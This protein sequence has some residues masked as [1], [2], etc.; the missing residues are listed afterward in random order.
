MRDALVVKAAVLALGSVASRLGAQKACP[1]RFFTSTNGSYYAAMEEGL[2]PPEA[3]GEGGFFF[4]ALVL[5]DYTTGES[6]WSLVVYQSFVETEG[7]VDSALGAAEIR[8]GVFYVS[9]RH[10]G[11]GVRPSA[12]GGTWI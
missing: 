10:G 1:E 5:P 7:P 12:R 2:L 11:A 3:L 4:G 9:V 6:E 8:P